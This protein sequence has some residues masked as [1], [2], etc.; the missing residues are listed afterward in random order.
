MWQIYAMMAKDQI[1]EQLH[2]AEQ[3]RLGREQPRPIRQRHLHVP[4]VLR[5]AARP[6]TRHA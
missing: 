2:E 5:R 1:Q 4:G 3:R 6:T